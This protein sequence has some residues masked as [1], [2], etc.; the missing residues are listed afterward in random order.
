MLIALTGLARSGKD[1]AARHISLKYGFKW[2]DFS[3]DVLLE[4][5]KKRNMAQTKENMS[6][7]GD[8]LRKKYGPDIVAQRL[9]EK[10]K[11]GKAKNV[12]VSGVRSPEEAECLRKNAEK[13]VLI[14]IT[15]EDTARIRRSGN[16]DIASR[17]E[18]DI[19]KKGFLKVLE[20]ADIAI[21]NNGTLW[22]FYSK[23]NAF[24]ASLG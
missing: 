12:V 2:F 3:R 16:S 9:I 19:K 23:I 6:A 18:N 13:F 14:R 7:I 20:M 5:L 4:E 15:A 10:I 17:D 22:E 21:E 1:T 11:A 24:M 8:E